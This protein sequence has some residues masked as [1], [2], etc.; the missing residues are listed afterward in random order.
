MAVKVAYST[1]FWC[2][3]IGNAFYSLGVE[4]ILKK[5]LGEENV[6]VVS[7]YQTYTTNLGKRLFPSKNQLNYFTKLDVDYFVL[8]GPVISKYFL[9]LWK[10]TLVEL[11]SKGVRYIILSAGMMKMNDEAYKEIS[12][13]FKNHPP[14]ILTSRDKDTY[15]AFGKY[16]D[17]A[18]D[19][20]CFS[21][22]APDFYHPAKINEQFFTMN[23]DKISEPVVSDK[24]FS[25]AKAFEFDGKTYYYK[26]IG[27]LPKMASKTDRFSDALIYASSVFPQR[28]RPSVAGD[29]KIYRTDHRFH[30]HYRRKIYSQ[31]NTLCSDIPYGYLDIY[32]NSKLTFSDRVHAC[33]VTLAFGHPAML[34]VKSTRCGLLDRVGAGEISKKPVSID[35]AAL[36]KEK[37]ELVSWLKSKLS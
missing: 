17:N 33:A 7:D 19:G 21:F 11:E 2:T 23:F 27:L 1:G 26:Q 30:P 12:E 6:S 16:A 3:N 29:Y 28:K 35:M 5:I 15:E 10:D 8:A 32:A 37:E 4:Y 31:A 22:F 36:A 13:F 20:I 9:K 18:Y 25:G 34:F 14:F 24:E